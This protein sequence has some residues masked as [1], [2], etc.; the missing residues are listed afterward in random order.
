MEG[1]QTLSRRL[2]RSE[3]AVSTIEF[4]LSQIEQLSELDDFEKLNLAGFPLI[5]TSENY[6]TLKTKNT[7]IEDQIFCIVDIETTAND[8]EH[9]QIIELGAV[10]V[11]NGKILDEFE[12]LVFAPEVPEVIESLTGISA[13]DLKD[14]PSL[15]KVLGD[16]RLFLKDAVFVAHNV[17]FDY[18][19]ISDSFVQNNYPPLLNRRLCTID[20][21]KKTIKAER[22][23]LDALREE[24]GIEE[25]EHHRAFWDAKSAMQILLKSLQNLP[26]EVITTEELIYFSKPYEIKK[27]KKPAKKRYRKDNKRQ[28][29]ERKERD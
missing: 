15:P 25:G 10:L 2:A 17:S 20:L 18:N 27:A 6:A 22:Y 1:F 3:L 21:A 11:Q 9:G 5:K 14:A 4:L 13:D 19:F 16:F 28:K 29:R 12:S 23:G 26:D 7:A 8:V 24:F